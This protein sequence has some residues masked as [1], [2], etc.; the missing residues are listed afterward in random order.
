MTNPFL[1][2]ASFV[3]PSL[4]R[5]CVID[6]P[7]CRLPAT[8]R[9]STGYDLLSAASLQ[10]L[11]SDQAGELQ[12]PADSP[13]LLHAFDGCFTVAS[14]GVRAVARKIAES[15]GRR[16]GILVLT[17]K[18]ADEINRRARPSWQEHHWTFWQGITQFYI[19]GGLLSGA[20]GPITVTAA[21]KELIACAIEDITVK[22]SPFGQMLPLAGLARTA[23]A[24]TKAMLLL[25][26]GQ[27]HVKRAVAFY[28]DS[29]IVELRELPLVAAGF[30][31]VK[32]EAPL[33]EI[34]Q[35]AADKVVELAAQSWL[36]VRRRDW[37]VAPEIAL[38]LACYL[39]NGHP[40][41][42]EMGY[43][44]RLQLLTDHL[45]TYLAGRISAA[46]GQPIKLALLHD[47]SAAA[48]VYTGQPRTAVLMLGTAIGVGFPPAID[49]GLQSFYKPL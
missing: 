4:N 7:G 47:G 43:Y 31:S 10:A 40:P 29:N 35:E 18:R 12:L 6:L 8:Y 1:T 48:L 23:A 44:G 17:L 49:T 22:R 45:Q 30:A 11:V 9:I 2:K 37:L 16:L 5:V 32:Q 15:Y 46:V 33:R 36:E 34:A 39:I 41:S 3:S 38:S 24:G 27:T 26:F 19:G 13:D 28:Q 21:K 14:P 20:M 25:D 42:S